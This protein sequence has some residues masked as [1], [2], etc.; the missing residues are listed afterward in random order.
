MCFQTPLLSA[1]TIVT[2]E[3]PRW[4]CCN[5]LCGKALS[6]WFWSHPCLTRQTFLKSYV[7]K[8]QTALFESFVPHKIGGVPQN[9]Y[10]EIWETLRGGPEDWTK[11]HQKKSGDKSCFFSAF[12]LFF[13]VFSINFYRVFTFSH[14]YKNKT[15]PKLS[16]FFLKP[17]PCREI[18]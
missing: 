9:F 16:P 10:Y 15:V 1:V 5:K 4:S 8:N 17:S 18:S 2:L 13:H 12:F 11:T 7:L 6:Y 14:F 3:R